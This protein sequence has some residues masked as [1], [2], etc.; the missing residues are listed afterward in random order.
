VLHALEDLTA[1]SEELAATTEEVDATAEEFNES[2]G[3]IRIVSDKLVDSIRELNEE[4]DKF[5]I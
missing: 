4:I 5:I 1:I 2:S 3:D